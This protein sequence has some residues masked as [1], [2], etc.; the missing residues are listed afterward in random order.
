MI[1]TLRRRVLIL[2]L[3]PSI[4]YFSALSFAY[5]I[6]LLLEGANVCYL[7]DKID[8]LL[9]RPNNSMAPICCIAVPQRYGVRAC[10]RSVCVCGGGVRKEKEVCV[11]VCVGGG[12]TGFCL[13]CFSFQSLPM[14]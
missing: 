4:L 3:M 1:E 6:P 7:L 14:A 11:C 5:L 2:F 8:L 10:V 12:A 9:L 13:L